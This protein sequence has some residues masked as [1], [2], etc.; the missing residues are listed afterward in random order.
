MPVSGSAGF[1][2]MKIFVPVCRPT[3]VARMLFFRVRWPTM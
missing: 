1:N 2:V 3:P